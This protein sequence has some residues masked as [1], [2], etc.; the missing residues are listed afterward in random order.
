[1]PE[2]ERLSEVAIRTSLVELTEWVHEASG[3]TF[4]IERLKV[5]GFK[6]KQGTTS[7]QAKLFYRGP[8]GLPRSSQQRIKFDITQ[9]EVLVDPPDH[10]EIFH[11]YSDALDPAPTI[12]C[13][14]VNEV[15]A[16]K[17][18]ALY[19][20][21]G[22]ARDVYDVVHIS[23]NFRDDISVEAAARIVAEKFAFKGLDLPTPQQIVDA[24]DKDGLQTNWD[25]QLR[26][27][28]PSLPD[29]SGFMDELLDAMAWWMQPPAAR[30]A[31]PDL[32][33]KPD[34]EV[35]PR[36]HFRRQRI[37]GAAPGWLPD[38]IRFAARN[39]LLVQFSYHGSERTIEPYSLRRKQTGNVLLYGHEVTKGGLTTGHIKSYNVREILDAEVLDVPFSPRWRVEL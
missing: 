14:S 31:P 3:I 6:N 24:I 30:P 36:V 5:E 11:G 38:E 35:L 32:A 4:P 21:Q 18:R 17:T 19:E 27:Q 9:H 25:Q 34:E 23:R 37:A 22:R 16:E 26:H 2:A 1:M 12:A 7:Y 20:R 13:Y 10:R 39:R 15:L 8:L 33:P 28:L 29:L